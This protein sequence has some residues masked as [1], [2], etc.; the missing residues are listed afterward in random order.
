M[1]DLNLKTLHTAKYGNVLEKP[2]SIC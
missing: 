2:T 1:T